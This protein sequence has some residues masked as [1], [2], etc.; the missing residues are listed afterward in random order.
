MSATRTTINTQ[1]TADRPAAAGRQRVRVEKVEIKTSQAGN[2]YLM[3]RL[4]VMEGPD[5]GKTIFDNTMLEGEMRRRTEAYFR[6][7]NIPESEDFDL[8]YLIGAELDVIVKHE[9]WQGEPRAK[10]D[11]LYESEDES[12][13]APATAGPGADDFPF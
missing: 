12:G 7:L 9:E 11:K 5:N 1:R 10:I 8:Q 3:W 2:E 6:V 4:R 13:T